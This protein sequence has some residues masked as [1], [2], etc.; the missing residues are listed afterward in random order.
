MNG[1]IR[2]SNM[3]SEFE[4]LKQIDRGSEFEVEKSDKQPN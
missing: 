4:I 1:L 3:K 2:L